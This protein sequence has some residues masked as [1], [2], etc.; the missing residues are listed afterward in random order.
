[1]DTR[2]DLNLLDKDIIPTKFWQKTQ[3]SAI[4]LGNKPTQF[5]YEIPEEILCFKHHCLSLRF[6]LANIQVACILGTPFFAAVEPH[7]STK[8][9]DQKSGYFIN[10]PSASRDSKIK[11]KLP[12]VS[13]PRSSSMVYKIQS[14]TLKIEELKSKQSALRISDQLSQSHI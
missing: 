10:I 14:K 4:G 11:V 5:S 3:M 13:T 7:G 6:L 9:R 2:S 1:M 8:F 12:I